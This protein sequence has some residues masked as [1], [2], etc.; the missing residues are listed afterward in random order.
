MAPFSAVE[1]SCT[2]CT[3]P[4]WFCFQME[5]RSVER[6]AVI[7]LK[8]EWSFISEHEMHLIVSV[9]LQQPEP[10][11]NEKPAEALSRHKLT[12][13]WEVLWLYTGECWDMCLL[14]FCSIICSSKLWQVL[15]YNSYFRWQA[16]EKEASSFVFK[17]Q[18]ISCS[19]LSVRWD[20]VKALQ[21][22]MQLSAAI[23]H[24]G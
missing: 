11:E 18:I 7:K 13:R 4:R 19:S 21:P 22:R 16:I 12:R 24:S 20:E 15:A 2:Y 17:W 10:N 3:S 5:S 23:L 9:C 1:I 14:H 8:T 6:L